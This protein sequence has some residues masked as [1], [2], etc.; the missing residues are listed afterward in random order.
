LRPEAGSSRAAA[1]WRDAMTGL[2]M[3]DIRSGCAELRRALQDVTPL[4]RRWLLASII[5]RVVLCDPVSGDEAVG[6]A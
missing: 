2:L 3:P 5:H 6:L 4:N 1:A